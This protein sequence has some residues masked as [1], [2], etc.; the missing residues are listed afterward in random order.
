MADELDALCEV[1]HGPLSKRCERGTYRTNSPRQDGL[2][3][4]GCN[5]NNCEP[6]IR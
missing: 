4:V 3:L 2:P 5:G 1:A 6:P